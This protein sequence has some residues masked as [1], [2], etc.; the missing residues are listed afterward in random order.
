MANSSR[1]SARMPRLISTGEKSGGG[2]N[3]DQDFGQLEGEYCA[4]IVKAALLPV[5]ILDVEEEVDDQEDT[6]GS[7]DAEGEPP[8]KLE[9]DVTR[10]KLHR[11]YLARTP[12]RPT[13]PQRAIAHRAHED[14]R[15][16]NEHRDVR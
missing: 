3:L 11:T 10:E 7:D 1:L 16:E 14:V 15:A 9:D 6:A 4:T 8:Q 2:K 13:R 5:E 12:A